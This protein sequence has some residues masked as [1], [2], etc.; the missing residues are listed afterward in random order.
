MPSGPVRV[1]SEP[2]V[3]RQAPL[4]G[5]AFRTWDPSPRE[6]ELAQGA[7]TSV[8]GATVWKMIDETL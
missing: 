1:A 5:F 2:V 7:P 4:G 8:V 6:M 3:S